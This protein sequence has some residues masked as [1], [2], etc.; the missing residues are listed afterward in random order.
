MRSDGIVGFVQSKDLKIKDVACSKSQVVYAVAL[1]CKVAD[2]VTLIF[3]GTKQHLSHSFNQ[4]RPDSVSKTRTSRPQVVRPY[5]H[6]NV[7]CPSHATVEPRNPAKKGIFC[8]IWCGVRFSFRK[9]GGGIPLTRGA[10]FLLSKGGVHWHGYSIDMRGHEATDTG[11]AYAPV[12]QAHGHNHIVQFS[13]LH[14]SASTW[15]GG[16][17]G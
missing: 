5:E 13:S 16:G 9:G 15:R 14:C 2:L 17:G 7:A 11:L 6:K 4:H 8:V 1:G 12:S 10:M 3:F